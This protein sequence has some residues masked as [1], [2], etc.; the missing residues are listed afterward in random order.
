M[1]NTIA[2]MRKVV[3]A[4]NGFFRVHLKK[5]ICMIANVYARKKRKALE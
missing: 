2:T 5:F 1:Q 4:T 3:G